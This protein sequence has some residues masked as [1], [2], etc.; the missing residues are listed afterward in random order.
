MIGTL[1]WITLAADLVAIGIAL[2]NIKEYFW[3]KQG[4]SLTIPAR[5]KPKLYQRT[6]TLVSANSLPTL[7]LGTTMLALAANAYELL[8]TAGF[9]MIYTRLLTLHNLSTPAYYMYL[10]AYNVIY[11]SFRWNHGKLF[12]PRA[13]IS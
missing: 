1:R 5:A 10:A 3:F 4:V 7:L 6:R 13:S 12:K 9:P 2:I 11:R 8:C